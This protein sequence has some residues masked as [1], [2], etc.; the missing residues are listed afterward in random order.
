MFGDS[1]LNVL[2]G[3]SFLFFVVL[4]PSLIITFRCQVC[5]MKSAHYQGRIIFVGKLNLGLFVMNLSLEFSF[6]QK[7]SNRTLFEN[8]LGVFLYLSF[9]DFVPNS[10]LNRFI[11][12]SW[13]N[14]LLY[15][16][17]HL[18]YDIFG[19]F[20]WY[21]VGHLFDFVQVSLHRLRSMVNLNWQCFACVFCPLNWL[22]SQFLALWVSKLFQEDIFN[23]FLN[24]IFHQC[25]H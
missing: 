21:D 12:L 16:L 3:P 19:Y 25:C 18:F 22:I 14:F 4:E 20:S 13:A 11:P 5:Q 9:C 8:V 15:F 17:T 6:H 10:S 23:S 7:V 1:I 2:G 24:L